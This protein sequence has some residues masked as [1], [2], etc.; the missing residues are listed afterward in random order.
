MRLLLLIGLFM[1]NS[2]LN[3]HLKAQQFYNF[4]EFFEDSAF[5]LSNNIKTVTLRIPSLVNDTAAE[6]FAV[7]R[8]C[9]NPY[10][11]LGQYEFNLYND[12]PNKG[13]VEHYHNEAAQRF[14]SHTYKRNKF[15][16]DSLR[17]IVE[18]HHDETGKVYFEEH[19]QIYIS[20]FNEW[21]IGYEWY[22]D[23]LRVEYAPDSRIDSVRYDGQKHVVEYTQAGWRYRNFYDNEGRKTHMLRFFLDNKAVEGTE[24]GQYEYIYDQRG[25][26][27]RIET[28]G[29]EIVYEWGDLGLPVSSYQRDRSSGKILGHHVFYEYEFR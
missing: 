15:G 24:V 4:E 27:I 23:T 16:R 8:L 3:N 11:K 12:A 26:L 1:G 19:H 18:Y 29:R 20:E 21:T 22:G 14:K 9:F 28:T 17:E 7:Q 10:G 13:Y 6:T 2:L 5:I 25:R